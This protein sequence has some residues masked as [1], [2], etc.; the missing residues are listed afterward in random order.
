MRVRDRAGGK[1]VW[2]PEGNG[3]GR[4]E[5]GGDMMEEKEEKR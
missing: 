3:G 5:G 4:R 1:M 2:R